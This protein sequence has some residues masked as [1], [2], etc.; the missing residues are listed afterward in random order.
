ME[1][2]F[3]SC[4]VILGTIETDKLVFQPSCPLSLSALEEVVDK[5]KD[6]KADME[7]SESAGI[8][9]ENSDD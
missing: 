9:E 2:Y 7:S 4:G 1:I 3:S 8:I 6:I 5:M